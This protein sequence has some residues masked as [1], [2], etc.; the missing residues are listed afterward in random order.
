MTSL[1]RACAAARA[2]IATAMPATFPSWSSHSPVWTPARIS[3]PS[4]ATAAS[5]ACAQRMARAGPSKVVK[6]PSPA[7]SRSSPRNRASSRRTTAW[8]ACR[9]F[10]QA[11]SPSS[12]ARSVE[13]TMSVKRMRRQHRFRDE[14]HLF[15]GDESLDL[16][17]DLRGEED[18]PVVVS[19]DAD[20]SRAGDRARDGAGGLLHD[21]PVEDKGR[22][23]HSRQHV[24]KVCLRPGSVE[25][26][27]HC[28]RR[29]DPQPVRKPEPI[30][31]ACQ[32]GGA[33]QLEQLV[34]VLLRPPLL[35][36][37]ASS[38]SGFSPT[39][40]P[41]ACAE[42]WNSASALVRSG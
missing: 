3:S 10:R 38:R 35:A 4:S 31:V 29:S 12:A 1:A 18:P 30:G 5:M 41:S 36:E 21:R 20:C 40:I 23:V 7:V 39:S 25:G 22:H 2:P 17:R 16:R 6:K 11:L 32:Q 24:A 13:P 26:V 37:S 9:R 14:R 8:C 15:A 27:G 42:G 33:G 28:R 19:G 34:A